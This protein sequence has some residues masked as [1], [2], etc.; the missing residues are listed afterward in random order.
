MMDLSLADRQPNRLNKSRENISLRLRP[1]TVGVSSC[2]DSNS[3]R[4]GERERGEI[5]DGKGEKKYNRTEET[6]YMS[7]SHVS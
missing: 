5:R 1:K 6:T 7:A 4:E 3:G 2:R